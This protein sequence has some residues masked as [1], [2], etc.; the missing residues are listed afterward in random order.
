V[1]KGIRNRARLAVSLSGVVVLS[2]VGSGGASAATPSWDITVTPSPAAVS[3]GADAGYI[4]TIRNTGKSNISQVYLTDTTLGTNGT[5]A[6]PPVILP[7]TYAVPSQGSCDAPGVRLSCAL[8]AIRSNRSASVTVAFSTGANATFTRI[9]EANTTGVAGDNP[10][11]SHGDVLQALGSTT[12]GSA[13][14]PNFAGRFVIDP[15]AVN[16]STALGATNR[17]STKVTPPVGAIGVSVA[18][19]TSNLTCPASNPCWSEASEIHVA[20]GAV[21]TKGFKVEVGI[22]KDL[23]QTVHGVYHE[24]DSPHGTVAGES[25]TTTCSKTTP[26]KT[27]PCLSVDKQPGGNVVVILWLIENG[28]IRVY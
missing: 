16:D 7:T 14:D 19:G 8:G 1:I 15:E 25:I 5:A 3:A 20:N 26:P 11:S 2:L 13:T 9:F 10:G 28:K 21:F 17:Q 27:V 6:Q 24:F 12:V 4:V 22:Y 23:S 18:D